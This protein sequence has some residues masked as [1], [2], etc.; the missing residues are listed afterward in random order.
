MENNSLTTPLHS[1][2]VKL[3]ARLVDFAGYQLPVQ[4]TGIIEEHLHCRK[5][6]GLFDISHMGQAVLRGERFADAAVALEKHSAT[7]FTDLKEGQQRYGLL[8]ND[9]AG[10]IDDFMAYRGTEDEQNCLFIVV[11]SARKSID[12][13]LI[14]GAAQT[15]GVALEII[16]DHAL[17]ALQGPQAVAVLAQL[18]ASVKHLKFLQAARLKLANIPCRL[19]RSG[20]TGEDGFEISIPNEAAIEVC[21]LLLRDSMVKP[22]GLGARDSL[23]LEAGLPLYGNEL[24]EHISPIEAGLSFAVS[25]VR[26]QAAN[27]PAAEKI[28]SQLQQGVRQKRVGIRLNGPTPARAGCKIIDGEMIGEITSGGFSP[29][30]N[31]PIAMA[32]INTEYAQQLGIYVKVRNK[33]LE[34][35]ICPLPFVSHKYYR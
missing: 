16:E 33:L 11:N 22:I 19:S 12:F 34:A 9:S 3:C 18:N 31:Q 15:I 29:S 35:S 27:F 26:R 5:D 20:Y 21:H 8:L 23:R 24:N 1:L 13:A 32:Y 17:I 2:H 10:I 14:E 4:Y 30:L 7:C 25:K 6:A 28:L